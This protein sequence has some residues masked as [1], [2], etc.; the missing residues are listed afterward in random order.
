MLLPQ[1][2]MDEVCCNEMLSKETFRDA[3]S[4]RS[5]QASSLPFDKECGM[6]A[7]PSFGMESSAAKAAVGRSVVV[8]GHVLS[9]EDLT[10]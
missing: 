5:V 7:A 10:S 3:D 6:S 8:K 9:G 2:N 4:L 1:L